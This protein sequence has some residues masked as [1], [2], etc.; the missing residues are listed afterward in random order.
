MASSDSFLKVVCDF[1]WGW[2][3]GWLDRVV[4][5]VGVTLR[6]GSG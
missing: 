6:R 1:F 4:V 5:V 2:V 3:R